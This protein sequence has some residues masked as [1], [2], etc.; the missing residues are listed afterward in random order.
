MA[1]RYGRNQRR[2]HRERIAQLE[3]SERSLARRVQY[4]EHESREA[5]TRALN[6]I[7]ENTD[8]YKYCMGEI[9]YGLGRGLADA[10]N[11]HAE[12]LL[13]TV[14]RESRT[15]V[16]FRMDRGPDISQG[17]CDRKIICQ[18]IHLKTIQFC[19]EIA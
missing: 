2:A 16:E 5:Y 7:I 11:P 8:L 1:K 12:K 15:E 14:L 19:Q 17:A 10:L 6:H 9:S 3:Q 18:T 13:D 4:A